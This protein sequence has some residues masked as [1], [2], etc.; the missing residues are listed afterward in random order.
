[1]NP[2][3]KP[4]LALLSTLPLLALSGGILMA[5][6][7]DGTGGGAAVERVV[8]AAQRGPQLLSCPGPLQ[9]PDAAAV[10]GGDAQLAPG[11][12]SPEVA[13][14]AIALEPESSLLFG[15]V[16]GSTTLQE[17]DGSIRSPRISA[18][19]ADGQDLGVAAQAQ[20]LG[21]S[22][23]AIPALDGAA[24]VDIQ[25]SQGTG[26]LSDAVQSTTTG[27]GDYRSLAV[28]RCAQPAVGAVFLGVGTSAG[29]SAVLVLRNTTERPAT[30]AVQAW[31]AEGPADMSGRSRVVVPGG[32]EVRVLLESIVPGQDALGVSVSTVGAPLAMNLQ[33][34]AREGLAPGG[35]EVLSSAG[36]P[37]TRSV[38]PG[39]LAPEGSPAQ[40][41]LM[42]P[43][44]QDGTA[45]LTVHGAD[46]ALA[47]PAP[48][49]IAVPAG[50]VITVPLDGA[51]GDLAV[52]VRSDVPMSVAARSTVR[53]EQPLSGTIAAPADFAIAQSAS[54]IGSSAVLALPAE[55]PHGGLSL[56]SETSTRVTIIPLGADGGAGTPLVKDLSA[57]AVLRVGAEELTGTNGAPAGLSIVPDLPGSVHGAW[58]QT[59]ADPAQGPL[60]SSVTVPVD[61]PEAAPLEVQLH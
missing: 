10:S 1:M 50:S 49:E 35:A 9:V 51:V 5:P 44:G 26:A 38:V 4:V 3:R 43:T 42:N 16:A 47:A 24:T 36:A 15:V 52:A 2:G 21:A 18:A 17:E 23:T 54:A 33:S 7:N 32:E 27:E 40:A 29:E 55:G 8:S 19:G 39:V 60:L 6:E 12:P 41:V 13:V 45:E 56:F 48:Q 30:A 34:T 22:A 61:G 25:G 53:S 20:D 46:G 57:G 37:S 31:T 58:V 28:T 14:R 59:Q 11:A